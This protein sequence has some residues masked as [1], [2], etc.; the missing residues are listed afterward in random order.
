MHC[1]SRNHNNGALLN[2]FIAFPSQ[3]ITR[4]PLIVMFAGSNTKSQASAFTGAFMNH[5][6]IGSQQTKVLDD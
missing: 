4:R 6:D 3:A 2:P 5:R 1:N